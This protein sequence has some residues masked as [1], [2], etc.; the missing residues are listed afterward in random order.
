[1]KD[2][3]FEELVEAGQWDELENYWLERMESGEYE[4]GDFMEV[5]RALGRQREKSRAGTLMAL[6]EDHLRDKQSWP[7]RLRVLKEII[8]HTPDPHRLEDRRDHLRDTLERVYGSR[9]SFAQLLRHF[10]F[11]NQKNPEDLARAVDKIEQWLKYDVGE[12]YYQPGYGAGKVTEINPK[13]GVIRIDFEKRKD[14]TV[15]PGDTELVAIHPGH[16]LYKKFQAPDEFRQQAESDPPQTL[17]RLLAAFGRP[18]TVGEIKDCLSSGISMDWSRW[19]TA[20]KKHPQVVVSGKGAQAEYSWSDSASAAEESVR[21]EFDAA[22]PR[23]RMDLARQHVSRGGALAEHFEKA[24]I[25]DAK[26]AHEN[27]DCDLA[28]EML[29]VFAKWPGHHVPDPGYTFEQIVKETDP[30]ALLSAVQN[31]ALKTRVI[32]AYV[33]LKPVSWPGIYGDWFLREDNPK[34]LTSMFQKIQE[35]DSSAADSLLDRVFGSLHAYPGALTWLAEQ[36]AAENLDLQ[37]DPIGKRLDGKFLLAVIE[38]IDS[39]EFSSLRNRIKKAIES[40]TLMNVLKQSINPDVALKAIEMLE[41]TRHLED[42]RRDRWR[43]FIRARIPEAKK[44]DDIIFSTRESY[45]RKRLELENLIKVELPTNRKAV[46]E[47]AALGDLREN[48]EYKAARERQEYLINRVQL[49]QTELGRVRVLEP[50]AT[51]C[52]EV[53]PG[54]RVLLVQPEK[55]MELTLLGPWDSDPNHGIYSYQAPIGELLMGKSRGERI[56]WNEE[57]WVVEKIEP[58][59]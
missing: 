59:S 46:G 58:W 13:L 15:E 38:A 33:E 32:A 37:A 19:W 25:L 45:E 49:L 53:R 55:S 6:L 35:N 16:V 3:R 11:D 47:A 51:D 42:Y 43:N 23:R 17:G 28:L 18:M 40:G 14:V 50:G 29:E 20:A 34:L 8:R 24:L 4:F 7:Q 52:S 30:R 31:S 48:H 36:A 2:N 10:Q 54:T 44:K 39:S 27:K 21:K 26:K 57:S 56:L 1:M 41:Y 9:P 5:A 22:S 12:L